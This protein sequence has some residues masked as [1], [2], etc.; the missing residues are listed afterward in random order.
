MFFKSSDRDYKT[1]QYVVIQTDSA[2]PFAKGRLITKKIGCAP[3]ETLKIAGDDY[4]CRE[5]YLGKAKHYSKTGVPVKPFNPC[6]SVVCEQV[7]PDGMYFVVGTHKDS[8]DS[9]YF[10]FVPKEKIVARV[11]PLW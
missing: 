5:E 6:G 9:R 2:D 4:F 1:G 10:G 11:I 7:V 3:G 8:Y